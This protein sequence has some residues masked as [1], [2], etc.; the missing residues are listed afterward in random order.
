MVVEEKRCYFMNDLHTLQVKRGFEA[1]SPTQ[2]KNPKPN[3]TAL[4][5]SNHVQPSPPLHH[6]NAHECQ[7][8]LLNY[9]LIL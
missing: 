5:N 2:P 4:K 3:Q 1:T 9:T 6:H 8:L 7:K